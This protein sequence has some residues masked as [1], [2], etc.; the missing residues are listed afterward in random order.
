MRGDGV[1]TRR[2]SLF[3]GIS[4]AVLGNATMASAQGMPPAPPPPAGVSAGQPGPAQQPLPTPPAQPPAATPP[5]SGAPV[6][7]PPVAPYPQG[8]AYPYPPPMMFGP[9]RLPYNEN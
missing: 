3:L 6:G 8:A 2:T 4:L 7:A 5:A 1:V 9:S